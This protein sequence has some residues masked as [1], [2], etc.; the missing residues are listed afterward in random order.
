MVLMAKDIG[1]FSIECSVIV[2]SRFNLEFTLI[3]FANIFSTFGGKNSR[4][5]DT[6]S[7]LSK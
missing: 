4:D 2:L 5:D 7:Q 1:I 3:F 6:S